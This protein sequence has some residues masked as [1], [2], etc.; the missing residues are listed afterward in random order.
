MRYACF[1]FTTCTATVW[2]SSQPNAYTLAISG[3]EPVVVVHTVGR[4][5]ECVWGERG[6]GG[7]YSLHKYSGLLTGCR[8]HSRGF[9]KR[10]YEY[11]TPHPM[12]IQRYSIP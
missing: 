2:Q 5:G 7:G 6:G 4:G 9:F 11:E 1:K 12:R 10:L 8:G 3:R